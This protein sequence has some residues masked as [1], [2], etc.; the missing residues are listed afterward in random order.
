VRYE[1]IKM[2]QCALV[3]VVDDDESVRESLPGLLKEAGFAAR[4]FSSAEEYLASNCIGQTR[5]LILDISLPGMSGPDLQ[6]ELKRRQQDIPIIF[7]TSQEDEAIR[8]RLHE[9]GA[10]DCLFKPFSDT[11]L[12]EAINVA[13]R[14]T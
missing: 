9:Q 10:V 14:V 11:A 2:N 3:S 7:I 4:A 6:Q 8:P 12:V 13:I 5:C 1:G